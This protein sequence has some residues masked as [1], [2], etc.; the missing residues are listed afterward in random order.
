M[1]LAVCH[2]KE[3]NTQSGTHNVVLRIDVR[4][5]NTAC[6]D[7]HENF[8]GTRRGERGLLNDQRG[9]GLLED[10]SLVGVWERH[11]VADL[12]VSQVNKRKQLKLQP[13]SYF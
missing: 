10:S 7:L 12:W 13:R 3:R 9:A 11:F 1:L 5:A 2:R 8:I 6:L 4:E